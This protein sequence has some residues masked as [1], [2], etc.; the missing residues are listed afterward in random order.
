MNGKQEVATSI[1]KIA[2]PNMHIKLERHKKSRTMIL[3][4]KSSSGGWHSGAP[5]GLAPSVCLT[6]L[7]HL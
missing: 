1:G 6:Q 2:K 5:S 4:Q 3:F 7:H